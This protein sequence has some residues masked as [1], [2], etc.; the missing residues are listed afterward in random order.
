MI[1]GSIGRLA[2]G[3]V[4]CWSLQSAFLLIALFLP[5]AGCPQLCSSNFGITML[6]LFSVEYYFWLMGVLPFPTLEPV[7]FCFMNYPALRILLIILDYLPI[8]MILP[9]LRPRPRP[10]LPAELGS[11]GRCWLLVSTPDVV[12]SS[13][14]L[15]YRGLQSTLSPSFWEPSISMD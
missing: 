10:K 6:A 2:A 1:I 4:L 15:V 13:A 14:L 3:R 9:L 5:C 11:T 12:V 8:A 7:L